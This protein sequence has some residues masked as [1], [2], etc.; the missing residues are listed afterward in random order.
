[1]AKTERE[2]ERERRRRAWWLFVLRRVRGMN[3]SGVAKAVGLAETSASTIGDWE[4]GISDP[5]LRQLHDLAVLYGV[6]SGFLKDPPST[7]EERAAEQM[8]MDPYEEPV[9]HASVLRRVAER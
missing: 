6:P 1:M 3:Q 9:E 5:S 4:R 2:F 8:G 7:D